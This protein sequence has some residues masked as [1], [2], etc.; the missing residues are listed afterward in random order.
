MEEQVGNSLG[1]G[2]PGLSISEKKRL[3]ELQVRQLISKDRLN[4]EEA[5]KKVASNMERS[6]K[7]GYRYLLEADPYYFLRRTEQLIEKG[8]A[9]DLRKGGK[10]LD[11]FMRAPHGHWT[12]FLVPHYVGFYWFKIIRCF[13]PQASTMQILGWLPIFLTLLIL[14]LYAGL[15]RVLR[16]P[17]WAGVTGMAIITLSPIFIQRSALGWYDTDPYNYIFPISILTFVF[18]GLKNKRWFWIGGLGG[19]FLTGLYALFW[20]GWPFIGILVPVSVLG[21]VAVLWILRTKEGWERWKAG[22]GFCALYFSGSLVF[23]AIFLT[24]QG[25]RDSL[26]MGW[27]ALNKFALADFDVWP[28]IFLTVGE[29]GSVTLQKLIFL[30]GNYV[31]FA[32]AVIGL[33]WE[34][35]HVLRRQDPSERFRFF[36]CLFFSG[37]ILFMSLKTERFSVLFVLPLA[38]FAGFAVTRFVDWAQTITPKVFPRIAS[39][40]GWGRVAA[41]SLVGVLFLPMLLL[42]AHVVAMGI[43][44]IMDDVWYAGLSELRSKTPEDSIVDSWWPPGHFISGIA[45]RRVILDGGTQEFH[46]SYWMAKVL[47]AE[48]ERE[49]AGILRMLNTSGEDAPDLLEKWGMD[50]PDAVDLILKIVRLDRAGALQAL[51]SFLTADQKNQ[52]LDKTHGRGM[53]PPSYVMVYNDLVEQNLAVSVIANWDF[54]KAKSLQEQKSRNFRRSTGIFERDASRRYVQDLLQTSGKWMNYTPIASLAGRQGSLLSFTNGLRV[55]LATK[56][57]MV[58]IPDKK[59]QGAPVSLFFLEQGNLV[60]KKSQGN[61]LNVSALFFEEGGVFYSVIADARLIRSLLFRLYYL[62]GQG[63]A[64]FKPVIEK[65]SL[66]GGTMVQIYELDREKIKD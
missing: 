58:V 62:K 66:S 45:H 4:F 30:T 50:V 55:D 40:S 23:L 7:V 17:F 31:T 64:Y 53:L 21:S 49:A 24:P 5:V 9:P 28:N 51:P 33:L 16:M 54:R 19:S 65:G 57:A 8:Q 20:P 42:S 6:R 1:K 11:R 59:I 3:A 39:G 22:V 29:A 61:V 35:V 60:E 37:P 48:D 18:L 10:Y 46:A 15:A 41:S 2:F 52:L 25:L 26:G 13:A 32:F 14:P 34:G 12:V 36:F 47:M 27:F 43:R 56:S 63:L 38:I 44:P